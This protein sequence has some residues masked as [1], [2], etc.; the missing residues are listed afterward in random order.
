MRTSERGDIALYVTLVVVSIVTSA[1]VIMSGIL[2]QQI[3]LSRTVIDTERAFY[4]ANS[5]LEHALYLLARKNTPT[6]AGA[7]LTGELLYDGDTPA[8][9]RSSA[10]L[11]QNSQP[12]AQ[13]QG[14]FKNSIRRVSLSGDTC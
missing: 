5:G 11:L 9:F 2:S 13:S 14:D 8:R 4:A 1:A 10:T 6:Q 7:P 12:C 3:R